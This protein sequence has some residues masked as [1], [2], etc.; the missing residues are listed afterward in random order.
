MI[1]GSVLGL[2]VGWMIV[3]LF[4]CSTTVT[5]TNAVG[6]PVSMKVGFGNRITTQDYTVEPS[7]VVTNAAERVSMYAIQTAPET[8]ARIA[9]ENTQ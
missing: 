5:S 4:G 2:L 3:S 6:Q 9:S 7:E 8:I 1:S